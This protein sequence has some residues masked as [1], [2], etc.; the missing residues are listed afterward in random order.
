RDIFKEESPSPGQPKR[1]SVLPIGRLE[2]LFPEEFQLIAGTLELAT[3]QIVIRLSDIAG[4]EHSILLN[5]AIHDP[6]LNVNVAQG[7]PLPKV[8]RITSWNYVGDYLKSISFTEPEMINREDLI[9][10]TQ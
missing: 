10:W 6:I 4:T 2:L 7:L 8:T 3:G 9:G 1:P 5:L